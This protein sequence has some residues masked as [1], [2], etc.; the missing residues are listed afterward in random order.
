MTATPKKFVVK[1]HDHDDNWIEQSPLAEY[2]SKKWT[3]LLKP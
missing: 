2:S 1:T 3:K